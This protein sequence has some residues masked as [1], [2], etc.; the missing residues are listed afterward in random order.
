MHLKSITLKGFKSFPDRTRLEFGPG[1]SVIVGPN[2]SGK[3]NIT[4]AVLWALGEQSPL[5]VRGQSMQD[6]IFG[7]ARGQQARRSAE[8]E[9]VI[10]NAD[11]A[12]DVE[13]SEISITRR[14][15]R[16]GEGEY[17]LNGARCR[18]VDVLEVLSDTGPGQGDALGRLAGPRRGD[19]DLQ[20][21]R[22]PP[23]DRGGRRAR[24]APQAPAPRPA[25]A[26]AHAGQPRPRAGRR[27]RGAR[28]ACARS[29]AR[30][31]PPSFTSG[32]SASRRGALGACARRRPRAARELA[33]AEA[34]PPGARRARPSTP[35]SPAVARKRE[36]AEERSQQRGEQR[37]R[38]RRAARSPRARPPSAWRCAS[39]RRARPRSRWRAR[40]QRGRARIE[41]SRPSRRAAAR[42][43]GAPARL[44]AELARELDRRSRAGLAEQVAELERRREGRRRGPEARRRSGDEARRRRAGGRTRDGAREL[45]ARP[46]PPANQ[47]PRSC[48]HRRRPRRGQPVPRDRADAPGGGLALADEVDVEPGYERALA[49]ASAGG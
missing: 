49:A 19:R 12:A 44:E 35:S 45:A 1:V 30:P 10:D 4:D 8:V 3:S 21:T 38:L 11:G 40:T 24:Q 42:R 23:A 16:T 46:M 7:G 34:A 33:A 25:Q 26:R 36:E 39:S 48:A 29:S 28:R 17:R 43:S 9:L 14:L 31:R 37:E 18:L 2:G 13:F 47:A 27:A 22:P 41:R 32:S 20:A 6:V 15:D 5:A